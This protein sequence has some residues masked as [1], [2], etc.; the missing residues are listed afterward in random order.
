MRAV[1]QERGKW[2]EAG[3][4]FRVLFDKGSWPRSSTA[5]KGGGKPSRRR[6]KTRI[7]QRYFKKERDYNFPL[8]SCFVLTEGGVFVWQMKKRGGEQRGGKK[9]FQNNTKSRE[10][11]E[12]AS[13]GQLNF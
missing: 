9:A 10:G 4:W 13:V 3:K 11:R 1:C 2:R 6:R 7:D 12:E 5:K 8:C